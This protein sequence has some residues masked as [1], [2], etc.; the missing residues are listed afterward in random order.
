MERSL[1]SGPVAGLTVISLL[2]V[3]LPLVAHGHDKPVVLENHGGAVL[4]GNLDL[5]IV[6]YGR[7]GRVQKN[8]LRAFI[9]S[10]NLNAGPGGPPQVSNWWRMVGSYQPG[11]G[12]I[13]VKVVKQYV[14]PNYALGKVMTKDFIKVLVQNAVAGLPKA[15]PVIFAA[16]DVTVEGL[17]MG[18]CADH[19]LIEQTPYVIVGNPETECPGA[20]AWPFYK[21][22]YGP[23]GTILKPPSGNV[24]AD[25][26]VVSLA[27]GLASVVTNPFNTGFFDLGQKSHMIE[28]VTACPGMFGTGAA[29]GYTGKLTVDPRSGG[30]YNAVGFK[31]KKFLLPAI[32]NPSTKSCWT[33]M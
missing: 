33:V 12:V 16:R 20:C 28:A 1:R 15:I 23:A 30:A 4:R 10:L 2:L 17:C 26:M 5:S 6:F 27:S 31:G 24:A 11:G 19:G 18:K 32:W 29:P 21:S 3:V 14:D 22:D 25:A 8:T 9:K 7:F 13:T